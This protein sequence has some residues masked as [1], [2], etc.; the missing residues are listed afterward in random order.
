VAYE[1]AWLAARLIAAQYGES[2]LVAFYRR[3]LAAG[4]VNP[5]LRTVLHTSGSRFTQQWRQ[6]LKS[7]AR[8]G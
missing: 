5:A 2:T 4:S 1:Q 3:V 7:T 6:Q 8:A